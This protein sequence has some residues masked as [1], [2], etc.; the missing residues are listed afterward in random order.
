[1]SANTEAVEDRSASSSGFALGMSPFADV[2][3]A[4]MGRTSRVQPGHM[5]GAPEP[6]LPHKIPAT[7]VPCKHAL[8][9]ALV[10]VP[11]IVSGTVRILLAPRSAWFMATGPSINPIATSD[12]P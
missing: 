8:L 12:L 2:V 10:H 4:K 7:K 5:A 1:M 6:L 3:S 11:F 9:F